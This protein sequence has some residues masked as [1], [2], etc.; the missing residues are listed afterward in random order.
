MAMPVPGTGASPSDYLM[1]LQGNSTRE[2]FLLSFSNRRN[3]G[4]MQ[5][6]SSPG[7]AETTS[8]PGRLS[9]SVS[10]YILSQVQ[11]CNPVNCSPPGFSLHGIFQARILEWV[12]ISYSGDLPN[13]G[14][15]PT[16]LASPALAGRFLNTA[17]PGKP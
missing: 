1:R 10:V 2:P 4:L 6:V 7:K 15:K 14:M 5:L 9:A 17:P 3:Q 16:S 11:L 13:L 12:A 8:E